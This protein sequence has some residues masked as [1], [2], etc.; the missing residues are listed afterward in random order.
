MV[1]GSRCPFGAKAYR[2]AVHRPHCTVG[3]AEPGD[4]LFHWRDGGENARGGILH[5][6]GEGVG[7]RSVLRASAVAVVR[8]RGPVLRC[9]KLRAGE[10]VPETSVS[11]GGGVCAGEAPG[12]DHRPVGGGTAREAVQR[13]VGEDRAGAGRDATGDIRGQEGA[14]LEGRRDGGAAAGGGER[15]VLCVH[16]YPAAFL[17]RGHRPVT[18]LRLVQAA[19]DV[20]GAY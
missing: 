1:K 8:R 11:L 17:Q 10:G 20:P 2:L 5:S 15:C 4:E 12:N 16:A 6:A 18:D 13:S 9:G 14:H 19:V 3:A 7:G